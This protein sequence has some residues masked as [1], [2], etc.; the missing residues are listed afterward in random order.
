MDI[1]C[2]SDGDVS[3]CDVLVC[4]SVVLVFAHDGDY[5]TLDPCDKR[6]IGSGSLA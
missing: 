3:L 4:F 1:D 6:G 5:K 2:W